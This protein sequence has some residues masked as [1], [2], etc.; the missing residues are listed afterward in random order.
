ML[1]VATSGTGCKG[2][3]C[4]SSDQE[5]E[6]SC[7][8]RVSSARIKIGKLVRD[9]HVM[10]SRSMSIHFLPFK[11]V[12]GD[13]HGLPR[14]AGRTSVED[15]G[16][17][18]HWIDTLPKAPR[19]AQRNSKCTSTRPIPPEWRLSPLWRSAL[20][21]AVRRG[22]QRQATLQTVDSDPGKG[23]FSTVWQAIHGGQSAGQSPLC[24]SHTGQVHLLGVRQEIQG[25]K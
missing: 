9:R 17:Q 11:T 8:G 23:T 19:S 15:V 16:I 22:Q 10:C 24:F 25:F 4:L 14:S 21:R 7:S 2:S 12:P 6:F 5:V 13:A 18:S 1:S 20:S 3:C